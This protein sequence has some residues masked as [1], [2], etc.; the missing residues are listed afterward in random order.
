MCFIIER[1]WFVADGKNEGKTSG[2]ESEEVVSLEGLGDLSPAPAASKEA[3]APPAGSAPPP[4]AQGPSTFDHYLASK[5]QFDEFLAAEDP[6][7]AKSLTHIEG[8]ETPKAEGE[9]AETLDPIELDPSLLK[10]DSQG[11]LA[12]LV[13]RLDRFL[14]PVYAA[15]AALARAAQGL[16]PQMRRFGPILKF[17]YSDE[18]KKYF[19]EVRRSFRKG[20]DPISRA[21]KTFKAMRWHGKLSI[22]VLI[23]LIF[24]FAH[25]FKNILSGRFLPQTTSHLVNSFDDVAD[26]KFIIDGERG[27]EPFDSP[28]RLTEYIVLL[29]R[30][31][32][33]LKAGSG[34]GPYPMG[35]FEVFIEGSNQEVAVEVK[36][37]EVE[38]LDRLARVIEGLSYD[39]LDTP[40]GKQH[41]KAAVKK[42]FNQILNRGRV[43]KVYFKLITLKP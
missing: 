21:M 18:R 31:V 43:K 9:G 35:L 4:A 8:L 15:R 30:I 25:Y 34:S 23:L 3:P 24:V 16:S 38:L 17:L 1:R 2:K 28:L 26:R 39:F 7:F 10:P 12:N 36:D 5:N 14:G 32:V 22:V 27:L 33:N 37:R 41:L 6:E 42:D 11:R 40:D 13:K 29:K 20:T 19:R